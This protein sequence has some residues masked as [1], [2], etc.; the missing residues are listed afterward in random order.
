MLTQEMIEQE[1]R[2]GKEIR[3]MTDGQIVA[4]VLGLVIPF[5]LAFILTIAIMVGGI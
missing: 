1:Q 4:L 2:E 5:G 3:F